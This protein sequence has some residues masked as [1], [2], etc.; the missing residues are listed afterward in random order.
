MKK[1]NA[2]GTSARARLLATAFPPFSRPLLQIVAAASLAGF[3]PA[4]AGPV[5]PT[6][7]NV[8][9][10]AATVGA[11]SN[12]TLT[13]TQSSSKAI[14]DWNSF[15]IGQGGTV[16]F[17]N[18]NGATLNRVTGSAA[19]AINGN[20]NATGSVYLVNSSAPSG[21]VF[22]GLD[23]GNTAIWSATISSLP[24]SSVSQS[25]NRY[26]F[27]YQPTLTVTTTDVTKTY[28]DDAT[29]AVASAYQ[30]NGYEA[31]V[32]GAFLGD[33]AASAF[34]GAPSVTSSGSSMTARVANGPYAITA[35]MGTLAAL[36]GYAI[37]FQNTGVLTV[38][39]KV[40]TASLTGTVEKTYDGTTAAT[41]TAA[42]YLLSGIVG[43]DSVFLND[44]ATGNYGTKNAGTSKNVYAGGL[45]L[46]GADASN[47][48][49]ASRT[50]TGKIG[51]IDPKVLTASL[52]GTTE[53]I[54]DGTRTMALTAA[55]YL[56]SGVIGGDDVALNDPATGNS[57]APDVG[58]NRNVWATGLKLLGTDARDYVLS[59]ATIVGAIGIIDPRPLTA[60]LVGSVIKGYDGNTSALMDTSN[61]S[62]TGIVNSD[63]VALND[64]ISGSYDTPDIGTGKLVTVIGVKLVG[65]K[66]KDYVLP[67]STLSAN[68]GT[69]SNAVTVTH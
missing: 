8:V 21:D 25:G 11:P 46:L 39:P 24:P 12:G 17:D 16:N 14:V 61:Y 42:N 29:A 41:L 37:H 64:P 59:S 15:S 49:L 31:G 62:V 68:I 19:S 63:D 4:F 26:I 55:N 44:P 54:Y 36:D 48:V 23:S 22:G 3:S 27:A 1:T 38:D 69:I 2:G 18:G 60:S 32:S 53:K 67:S 9:S 65:T 45:K 43:S 7:G 10:G 6:N 20:L 56:L 34:S 57:G 40:L 5:L 30:V 52:V 47:Y 13:V 58:K 35:S 33:N 28:G 50:A 51:I 66:A